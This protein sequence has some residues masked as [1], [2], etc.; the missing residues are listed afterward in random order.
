MTT[1]NVS[2]PVPRGTCDKVFLR[3]GFS[4]SDEH[5]LRIWRQAWKAALQVSG[6]TENTALAVDAKHLDVSVRAANCLQAD[7][8]DLLSELVTRSASDLLKIPNL[9]RKSVIEIEAGLKKLG[10]SLK[11]ASK[12]G[13]R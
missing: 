4:L 9:G 8:I 6:G 10:L 2:K 5:S 3:K 13:E 7:G 1:P 12:I 11:P